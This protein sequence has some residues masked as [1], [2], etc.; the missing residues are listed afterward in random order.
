M[1]QSPN[2]T[3]AN[4]RFSHN[5]VSPE[6]FDELIK[7][8]KPRDWLSIIT[9]SSIVGLIVLW[10]IL[11]SVPVKVLGKGLLVYREK[12]ND[13]QSS[14]AGTIKE[15]KVKNGDCLQENQVIAIIDPSDIKQQLDQERSKL[16]QLKSQDSQADLLQRQQTDLKNQTIEQQKA[17]LEQQLT[18]QGALTPVLKQQGIDSI[19][20]Q[21]ASI[22]QKLQDL[23]QL[24]PQLQNN[25]LVSL[26]KQRVSLQQQFRNNQQLIPKL[27]N[28][29]ETRQQLRQQ[30]A[31][32]E[33]QVLQSEL[34]YRDAVQK[35]SDIEA[36]LQ[37]LKLQETQIQ[38]Q[39]LDNLSSISEYQ[40][41]LKELTVQ[42][43]EA[44]RKSQENLNLISKLEADIKELNSQQQGIIQRNFQE[45]TA[46]EN[47]ILATRSNI[48]RLEKQ[49]N[50]N[51]EIKSPVAGCL[52][53]LTVTK[54]EV[55]QPS[56]RLGAIAL[57]NNRKLEG[58][59]Y[60]TIADG[61]KIKPGMSVQITPD[62]V[63][64]ERFGGI[65]GTVTEVSSFPI[66]SEAASKIIGNP[67]IIKALGGQGALI[68]V[69]SQLKPNSNNFSGY[70]W[71]SS[72]G[73]RLQITQGTTT[74][75]SVNIENRRP[76]TF[77][78]PILREWTGIY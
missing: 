53:E 39:Y 77:V 27:K 4:A 10:G 61:K 76:I 12:I 33:D 65:M 51:R 13:L 72:E 78:I 74:T 36:K 44:K 29:W 14:I 18:T 8:V 2:P 26:E 31:L 1:N 15:I 24:N 43:T 54:G 3:P 42:E 69:T 56:T 45:N 64:R 37:E 68:A 21:K 70:H 47:E 60:F 32:S 38:K 59:T 48:A 40:A 35:L 67:E 52:L 50:D 28:R 34:E 71:S 41:Q 58:V 73:P 30:G 49:Y 57:E 66:T 63:K 19:N 17:S 46:R 11:G 7:I 16:A 25:S 23:Q 55:V 62:T 22:Q 75:V 20:Q 5:V 9:A 6:K